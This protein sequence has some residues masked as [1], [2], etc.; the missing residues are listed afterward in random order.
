MDFPEAIKAHLAGRVVRKARLLELNFVSEPM[1]L[2][3]GFGKLVTKDNK[4]WLGVGGL[5]KI[6]GVASTIGGKAP[7]LVFTL[8]GVDETFAAKAK[9]EATEYF[10]RAAVVYD[11]FFDEEWGLLDAPYAVSFGLM[12]KFTSTREAREDGFVRTVSISAES[13]FAAKKR[14]KFAYLT[15]QDQRNR[16]AG[17]AFAD[18]TPGIDTRRI[19]FPDF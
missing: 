5:G 6:S 13:P 10:D 7:E 8:S 2:W 19:T 1:G 9:G 3:N 15:P 17:D 4:V 11:Q 14:A 16:H 18:D 12:R